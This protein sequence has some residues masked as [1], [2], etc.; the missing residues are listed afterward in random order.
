MNRTLWLWFILASMHSA[1]VQTIWLPVHKEIVIS[2]FLHS[3]LKQVE[4]GR[5]GV[6][7]VSEVAMVTE[8]REGG[9]EGN[10][11]SCAM[12]HTC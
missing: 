8:G 9:R 6:E 2:H 5:V 7:R 1:N 10:G 3:L 12:L 4:V 11:T